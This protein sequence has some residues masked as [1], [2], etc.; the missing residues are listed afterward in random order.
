M[1]VEA[2]EPDWA[3]E[4]QFVEVRGGRVHVVAHDGGIPAPA[5]GGEPDIVGFLMGETYAH[6]GQRIVQNRDG[7]QQSAW[8]TDRFAD[9]RLCQRCVQSVPED[10]RWR[11]FEH[12]QPDDPEEDL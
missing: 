6:C 4:V 2:V 7:L 5:E 9:E 8:P 11:L 12:A 1:T 3:R 10:D